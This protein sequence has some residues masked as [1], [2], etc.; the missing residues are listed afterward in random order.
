MSEKRSSS[1][2]AKKVD[3]AALHEIKIEEVDCDDDFDDTEPKII[4]PSSPPK[5]KRKTHQSAKESEIVT[6]E[7]CGLCSG[8]RRKPCSECSFCNSGDFGQC[9]DLYCT[10]Q[11]EGRSQREAARE[12]YLM[13]L[14]KARLH[15]EQD[16]IE[17]DLEEDKP[18]LSVKQQIDMIMEEIGAAQKNRSKQ[19]V[20]KPNS[21]G[22][23]SPQPDPSRS[24]VQK[25]PNKSNSAKSGMQA[26][27]KDPL[28]PRVHAQHGVYGGSSSAAKSRR[29]GECE[30]CMRDDCGQCVPCADKPRFGGPGTKKKACVQRFCRTR[31]L[32]EDHAQAN[33]PLN[34]ADALKAPR[35]VSKLGS[36]KSSGSITDHFKIKP[37]S[38]KVV[39]VI[40]PASDESSSEVV[41]QDELIE[42][43]FATNDDNIEEPEMIEE[44][45][46]IEDAILQD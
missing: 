3:Y 33:F 34:S 15:E 30:G 28:K 9:I 24:K 35:P 46:G 19:G 4:A 1:T 7:K 22:F 5:K 21:T 11:K 44:E 29:C 42:D 45:D 26:E 14:G 25:S 39:E 40:L 8:C 13:S 37:K 17:D 41:G 27:K 23:V 10:N 36:K 12:A 2:R 43:E 20:T 38:E 6:D 16:S 18:N 31:K 32:E